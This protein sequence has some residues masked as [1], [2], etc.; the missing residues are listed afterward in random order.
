MAKENL[1]RTVHNR[2]DTTYQRRRTFSLNQRPVWRE[3]HF[4]LSAHNRVSDRVQTLFGRAHRFVPG[5]KVSA[6]RFSIAPP[7]HLQV[8]A[9][10]PPSH[11]PDHHPTRAARRI[12]AAARRV[13]TGVQN[14]RDLPRECMQLPVSYFQQSYF[15]EAHR[16]PLRQ[17]IHLETCA[18]ISQAANARGLTNA[19]RSS[20]KMRA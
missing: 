13:H 9:G 11:A 7:L 1:H 15:S 3:S 10:W 4:L 16:A 18:A 2:A 20:H 19:S 12:I 17:T 6:A 5:A 8:D 14:W